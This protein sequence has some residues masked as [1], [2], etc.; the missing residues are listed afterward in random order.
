L[1]V[2]WQMMTEVSHQWL[3][4]SLQIRGFVDGYP[5][6]EGESSRAGFLARQP[7][8]AGAFQARCS[9]SSAAQAGGTGSDPRLSISLEI[10]G[11]ESG[12]PSRTGFWMAVPWRS[13]TSTWG[14][15][16]ALWFWRVVCLERSCG[17]A[18]SLEVGGI[19]AVHAWGGA[20]L[21]RV[22]S[23]RP[24]GSGRGF[25]P[26]QRLWRAVPRPDRRTGVAHP[27]R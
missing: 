11:F 19:V 10:S 15:A 17:A 25:A 18:E 13:A 20:C 14:G 24:A 16:R 2:T 5:S 26:E 22:S 23:S 12:Y 8:T 4:R 3:W 9:S 6:S 27:C 1:R 21:S 7:A